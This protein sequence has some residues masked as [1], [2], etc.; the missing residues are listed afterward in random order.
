MHA[1]TALGA[2]RHTLAVPARAALTLALIELDR[3]A[4]ADALDD[5]DTP[6][7]LYARGRLEARPLGRTA[8]STTSSRGRCPRSAASLALRGRAREGA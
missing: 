1:T 8:R 7:L 4:D 6:G 5:A 2:G 3:A